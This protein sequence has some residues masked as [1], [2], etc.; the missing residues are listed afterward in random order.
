MG[1]EKSLVLIKPDAVERNLIGKVLEVYEQEDLTVKHMKMDKISKEFAKIHY[2]EHKGKDFFDSLINYITRGKLV[3]LV[4]EGENAISKIR[5][6][7]GSVNCEKDSI[8][9]I[10]RRFAISKTENT[11]HASD[12]KESA[13]REIEL[14]FPNTCE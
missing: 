2:D 14:W 1:I 7:N 4:L 3:A 6:I 11:V 8:S 9:T 10:R 13:K 12:S 5:D